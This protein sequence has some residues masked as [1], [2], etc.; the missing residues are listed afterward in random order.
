MSEQTTD[1]QSG[2]NRH[3]SVKA[4]GK[5]TEMEPSAKNTSKRLS[6]VAQEAMNKSS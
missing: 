4:P 6:T 2:K 3:E 5:E 1:K